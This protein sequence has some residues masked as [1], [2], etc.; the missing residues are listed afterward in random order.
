M[1]NALPPSGRGIYARAQDVAFLSRFDFVALNAHRSDAPQKASQLIA[2][3][4]RVWYYSTPEHWR[5]NVWGA[6]I[7]RMIRMVRSVGAE[8]FIADPETGWDG[9]PD[10]QADTLAVTL[11]AAVDTERVRVGVTS[12]PMWRF[13]SRLAS[14]LRGRAWGSPQLYARTLPPETLARDGGADSL[15]SWMDAWTAIWGPSHVIP[16][17]ALWQH[18]GFA[19]DGGRE[20]YAR[21]LAA[22]PP[23]VGRI[24]WSAGTG[25][26]W[27]MADYLASDPAGNTAAR[28]AM[29]LRGFLT[30]PAGIGVAIAVAAIAAVIVISRL[31]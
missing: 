8:G 30:T 15:R 3:G 27:M 24:G 12:Y 22:L 5:P 13:Q 31:R 11:R 16:G 2:A 28:A 29:E 26:E 7:G 17:A 21:Y 23:A 6:E 9:A 14:H 1:A 20:R 4:K 10:A 18:E 25:P 19:G